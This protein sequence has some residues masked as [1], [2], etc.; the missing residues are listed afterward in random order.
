MLWLL[1]VLLA[2]LLVAAMPLAPAPPVAQAGV[3]EGVPRS[4][5]ARHDI[6]A[7]YRNADQ[8][9]SLLHSRVER[10]P[11]L[12]RL[13]DIGDSWQRQQPGGKPGAD[14]WAI[15]LT[16]QATDGPKPVF[17]LMA[18]MHAREIVSAEVATRFIDYLLERYGSDPQVTW[19]LD[20]HE[21]VVVPLVNPDGYRLVEQGYLQRKN[22][23]TDV[24]NTC[25][26]SISRQP[27]VDLNRNFPFQW[28]TINQPTIDPCSLVFPGTFAAS[29]P[30]TRALQTLI[31]SLYPGA[32]PRPAA[33]SPVPPDT[34][35]VLINLHTYSN[36]VLWPWSYTS[37]LP[38]DS[39]ALATLGTRLAHFNGYVPI[40][41][42]KL[43]PASGTLDDWAYA[44]LGV[45]A[46]PCEIGPYWGECGGF[47]PPY[48]CMDSG[49]DGG[50]FWQRNLP[51]LLYAASVAR[52]PYSLPAGPTVQVADMELQA[53]ADTLTVTLRL[54]PD[55]QQP[56]ALALSIGHS[57]WRGGEALPLVAAPDKTTW[58]GTLPIQHLQHIC[59]SEPDLTCRT[60][61]G[62]SIPL[63][64]L[65][66]RD[67][68]GTWGPVRAVWAAPWDQQ[69]TALLWLPLVVR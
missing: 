17:V 36:L 66:A 32:R 67:Y 9:A 50:R 60:I 6:V 62:Q 42:V 10:Y 13:E 44:E 57:P 37:G 28:G 68:T 46:L 4:N 51:A 56:D 64:L 48:K 23:N 61:Q 47:W 20:E 3:Q 65:Q 2:L 49:G 33:G 18:A 45:A 69:N 30:E 21:I 25:E 43:Y 35:G 8:I 14:L 38:P 52:A 53:A 31:R 22:V 16:N 59:A 55:D 15:H 41:S 1:V 24:D 34:S 26:F 40:Q 58:T 29:E 11:T 7:G 27:G 63:L 12:A 54:E 39:T 5:S 19:L